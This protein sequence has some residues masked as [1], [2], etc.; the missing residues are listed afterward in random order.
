MKI[1]HPERAFDVMYRVRYGMNRREDI[2]FTVL[3]T[4]LV[5][6]AVIMVIHRT[7]AL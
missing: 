5:I 4:A 6:I 3:K 7:V 1:E 2:A